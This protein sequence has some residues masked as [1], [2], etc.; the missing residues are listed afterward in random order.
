MGAC[1]GGRG[2]EVSG[3]DRLAVRG[4]VVNAVDRGHK[5]RIFASV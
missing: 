4:L 2:R 5:M 1:G 3:N